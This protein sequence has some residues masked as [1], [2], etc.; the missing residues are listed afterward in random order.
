MVGWLV[1]WSLAASL[2]AAAIPSRAL[3][4]GSAGPTEPCVPGTVWEDTASGVKYLCVYDE[5][6][7]GPRWVLLA[8]G[9]AGKEAFLARSSTTGCTLATVGLTA[10]GGGGADAFV[11]SYRWP[12]AT[13]E[14]RSYQPAGELRVRIQLQRYQGGWSTCR[15]SG[16]VY[17]TG[18]AWSWTAGLDMGAAADCGSGSYRT[19]G[20]AGV[21][22][23]GAWRGGAL[24]GPALSLH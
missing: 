10:A 24:V 21:Y 22:Q 15:D 14:D 2:I 20:Y 13:S 7:G 4:A 19:L 17:S 12:C 8:T 11:R 18:T 5:S 6:Y 3:A 23:G 9:Q 1:G 16:Y